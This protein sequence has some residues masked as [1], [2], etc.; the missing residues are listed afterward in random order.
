MI[1][2]IKSTILFDSD[3]I[4]FA[5][6]LLPRGSIIPVISFKAS[7]NKISSQNNGILFNKIQKILPIRNICS[8]I[9]LGGEKYE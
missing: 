2:T 9:Y 1:K 6:C 4:K 5:I 7:I 8:I 3:E